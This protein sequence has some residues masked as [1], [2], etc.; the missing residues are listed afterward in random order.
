VLTATPWGRAH[1]SLE[2]HS[3]RPRCEH[4]FVRRKD[5]E[6][7]EARRLRGELGWSVRRIARELGVAQSSVSVWVRDLRGAASHGVPERPPG[8]LPVRSLLVWR[9]GRL[10]RCSRCRNDLPLE[11]FNRLGDGHQWYCRTC[12]AA[13]FRAR[14]E[15]HRDQSKAAKRAR[16]RSLQAHVLEYLRGHPCVDCGESDPVVLEFDHIREKTASIATLVG[17]GVPLAVLEAEMAR[18]EVVCVNCHR[19]RTAR[20]GRWRRSDPAEQAK[21]PYPTAAVARNFAH[22]EALL[23]RSPCVDCGERDP[24]V[25]EFDHVGAKREGDDPCVVRLQSRAHRFRDRPLRDSLRQLPPPRDCAARRAFSV[26][27]LKLF[28]APV[29]QLVEHRI[30]NPRCAGSSPAG[31][32]TPRLRPAS[33]RLPGCAL[34]LGLGRWRGGRRWPWGSP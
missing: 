1:R 20:R 26:P 23:A 7:E 12:F 15:L 16:I 13:Y 10:R 8:A 11:L 14:G 28:D 5:A 34:G 33:G 6:R 9:S 2:A 18:C 27:G 19:R 4:V 24:L 30:F 3:V 29:A 17:A 21:R 31:G 25:L 22:L 32:T